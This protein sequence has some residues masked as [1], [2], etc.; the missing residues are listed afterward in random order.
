[1]SDKLYTTNT[2]SLKA[3]T[4]D[5]RKLNAKHIEAA[6]IQLNGQNL[7]DKLE[8]AGLNLP[9]DYPKLVTR[10]TFEQDDN[11][12]LFSDSGKMVYCSFLDK[13]VTGDLLFDAMDVDI[14]QQDMP[15]LTSAIS[16]F[17]AST[18]KTFISNTPL[19]TNGQ[20]MFGSCSYL[21]QFEGDLTSLNNGVRMFMDCQLDKNSVIHILN[22][23]KH[24]NKYTSGSFVMDLSMHESCWDD[25]DIL[26]LL[27][28]AQPE[29]TSAQLV[30][31]KG[32]TW[33]IRTTRGR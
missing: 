26:E 27:P 33:T 15:L 32:A 10:Q 20:G 21:T 31:D 25:P 30:T 14:I 5:I 3:T 23:L 13:L 1:M 7:E 19:L 4:A 8:T 2:A 24:K 17:R 18:I 12:M 9:K 16:M 29:W 22:N 11:Y 28:G 6:S